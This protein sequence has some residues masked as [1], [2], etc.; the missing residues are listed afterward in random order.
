MPKSVGFPIFRVDRITPLITQLHWTKAPKRI[1]FQL[2]VLVY[3]CL[4]QS[5]QPYLV[6]KFH[7]SLMSRP[8]SVAVTLPHRLLSDAPVFQPSAIELFQSPLPNCGTLPHY[9]TSAPSDDSSLRSFFP[10]ILC[11]DC[12]FGH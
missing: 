7:Q 5:A 8:V 3:R 6:E 2:A 12:H 4:H 11:S 10:S 1:E 9:V